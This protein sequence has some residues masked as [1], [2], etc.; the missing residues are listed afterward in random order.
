MKTLIPIILIIVASF[1]FS[2][3][4]CDG[5]KEGYKSGWVYDRHPNYYRESIECPPPRHWE[6]TYRD[7]LLRGFLDAIRDLEKL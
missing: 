7:G 1:A 5:Y 3:T 4:F 2:K 6:S